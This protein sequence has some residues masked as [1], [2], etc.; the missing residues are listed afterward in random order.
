MVQAERSS[1]SFKA[2]VENIHKSPQDNR[3]YRGLV[4]PNDLKA[5]VISDPTTEKAGVALDV[6]IGSDVTHNWVDLQ[7]EVR[8]GA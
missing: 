8:V 7:P 6:N 5:I 1:T 2:V 4:L 3:S